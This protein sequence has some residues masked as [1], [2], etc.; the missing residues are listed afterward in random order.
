LADE[1]LADEDRASLTIELI[2]CHAAH[3]VQTAPAERAPLWQ[4]ARQVAADFQREHAA[5]PRLV[6]VRVQDALTVLAQ[7]EL[8]R[9]EAEILADGDESLE[10]ARTVLREASRLLEQLD[11]ELT[12]EIPLRHRRPDKPGELTADELLALQR[13]VRFHQARSLR[14][15][16]LC[17]PPGGAD[18]VAML[19]QAVDVLKQTLDQIP[20]EDPFAA[21]I[22]V[23]LA[24]CHR[25]NADYDEAERVLRNVRQAAGEPE[26]QLAARA[27]AV[28]VALARVRPQ[29]ALN[30]L[31]PGRELD[32]RT[33]AELDLAQLETDIALWKAASAVKDEQQAATWRQRAVEMVRL[34]EELHGPFWGRRADLLLVNS[35]GGS[36]GLADVEILTRTADNLVR[37]QQWD[38]AVSAYE[39]AAEAAKS[40]GHDEQ[41]FALRYKAG[42]VEHTRQN[43]AAACQRLRAA[44]RDL[45]AQPKAPDAHLL[46]AWN[47]AQR[48]QAEPSALAEYTDVLTEHLQLWPQAR[49][50]ETARMWLGRLRESQ[51]DWP[52]AA[53]AYQGVSRGSEQYR[54]ALQAAA[55]CWA[56][57]LA[58]LKARG[59]SWEEPARSAA[60]YFEGQIVRLLKDASQSWTAEDRFCAEQAAGICLEYLAAGH[61]RAEPVLQ[62]AL[63]GTP[64]PDAAWQTKARSLL[65]IALAGQTGKRPQAERM[66]LELGFDSSKELVD[67]L[68]ALSGMAASANP[69]AKRELAS[70]Q[71]TVVDKLTLPTAQLDESTR[72]KLDRV[73]AEALVLAGRREEA[74]AAYNKLAKESPDDGEIQEGYAELLLGADDRA[75]WQQA[76]DQW[77]RVAA[78][79]R[80]GT[81]R[82]YQARYSIAVALIKLGQKEEAADRIRYL[83]AT[84]P[85]LEKT[86]WKDKFLDLLKRCEVP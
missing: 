65:V 53:A 82:W 79:T 44:G 54:E 62:A 12:R 40:A 38:E 27:E 39:K 85:D 56:K 74:V 83:Q 14:N 77:R 47:A 81:D 11:E 10:A 52:A 17:Y 6:L 75:S 25:L 29:E 3:A 48:A 55:R 28:R 5:N 30:L 4:S 58:D 67:I 24:T 16:A 64:P 71:L 33:S 61:S 70:L 7:A 86:T 23:D 49:T 31:T 21:R 66:L 72:R 22:L 13:H 84:S 26:V 59:E 1:Q 34:I 43:H 51:R 78:R 69:Q 35:I 73:R 63:R 46:A 8:S 19:T 60:E 32:G 18:R 36:R 15:R 2:R 37:K 41:T 45:S 57:R 80:T 76:L 20:P 50:A 68:D 42:L 9:Q